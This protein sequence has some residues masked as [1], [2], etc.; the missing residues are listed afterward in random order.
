LAG[1]NRPMNYRSKIFLLSGIYALLAIFLTKKLFL[2]YYHGEEGINL[3]PLNLFEIVIYLIA[4]LTFI[5]T[6][7]TIAVLVKRNT[8]PVSFKK[9]FH[10]LIPSFMGWIILYLLLNEDMSHLIVPASIIIY[11]LIL[12][13][14]NRY[15]GSKLVFFGISLILL[16]IISFFLPSFHWSFLV[17]GFGVFPIVFGI[18]LLRNS[19]ATT[20]EG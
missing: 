10:F 11:G 19:S 18:L 12:I 14:L 6:A 2:S 3:L 5:I 8:H 1:K 17:M 7:V 9:R 16:G 4:L 15:V 20:T 13:N